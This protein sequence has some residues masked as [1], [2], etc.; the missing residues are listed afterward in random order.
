MSPSPSPLTKVAVLAAGYAV[1]DPEL[2]AFGEEMTANFVKMLN[3]MLPVPLSI[4][5]TCAAFED[6]DIG[7]AA[8]CPLGEKA[9]SDAAALAEW[10]E[11]EPLDPQ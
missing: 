8:F 2:I 7:H 1:I 11:L 6:A 4:E 5:C 10:G 3:G 9:E